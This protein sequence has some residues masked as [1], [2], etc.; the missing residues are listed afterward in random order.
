MIKTKTIR[1]AK[2][3]ACMWAKT[4]AYRDLARKP[5]GKRRLGRRDHRWDNIKTGL[6]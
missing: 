5:E 6:K 3:A 1:W 4:N 2:H